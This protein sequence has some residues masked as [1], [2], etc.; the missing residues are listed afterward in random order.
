M[1]P[2]KWAQKRQNTIRS[3]YAIWQLDHG[4][5]LQSTFRSTVRI[6]WASPPGPRVAISSNRGVAQ[7]WPSLAPLRSDQQIS[8]VQAVVFVCLFII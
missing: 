2:I 6:K 7:G 8:S 1:A 3:T 5:R 4:V